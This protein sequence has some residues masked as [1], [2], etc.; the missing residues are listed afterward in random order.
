MV[1]TIVDLEKIPGLVPATDNQYEVSPVRQWGRRLCEAVISPTSPL[2]GQAVRDADFRE[3]Y[4]AA[5]V[6]VHRNGARVTNKVGD[7][8]LRAGDTLLLQTGA[9]RQGLPEQARLLSR[10]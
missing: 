2:V 8:R 3:L 6:A 7:I 9:V 4:D 10:E 5:I 1:S